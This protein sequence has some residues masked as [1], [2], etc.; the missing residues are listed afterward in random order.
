MRD[1]LSQRTAFVLTPRQTEITHV[2]SAGPFIVASASSADAGT[3]AARFNVCGR[4]LQHITPGGSGLGGMTHGQ[5]ARP[6]PAIVVK[7]KIVDN[8]T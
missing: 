2:S 4:G 5:V 8:R 3:R 1:Q 7:T 6:P